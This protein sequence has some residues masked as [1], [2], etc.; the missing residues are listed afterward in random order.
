MTRSICVLLLL[1][2]VGVAESGCRKK[3]VAAPIVLLPPPASPAPAVAKPELPPPPPE[4]A[5]EPVE[6]TP[7]G[8]A[9]APIP[10]P[11]E[12]PP[13]RATTTRP[14]VPSAPVTQPPSSAPVPVLGPVLTPEQQR[15]LNRAIDQNL[16]R[17]EASIRTIG[18]RRLSKE[19]Q[20]N[21][22]E[23]RTFIRQTQARRDSDLPG[24]SR[25]AERAA[26]LADALE[27]SV[28]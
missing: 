14:V 3:H 5:P 10:P 23:I 8:P 20:A 28:R 17:V 1:C 25:L 16:G 2:V 19:Q 18:N 6:P 7:I 26:V 12:R 13:R 4:I 15:E 9:G 22:R 27:K 11:P 21:L 24:A